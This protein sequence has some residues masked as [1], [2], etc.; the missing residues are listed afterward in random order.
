MSIFRVHDRS[1]GF[2]YVEMENRKGVVNMSSRRAKKLITPKTEY[3][4]ESYSAVY[5]W[6]T[7]G[8]PTVNVK[9]KGFMKKEPY[10][11]IY[12]IKIS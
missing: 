2:W 5:K 6:G 3:V 12:N 7:Y 4:I 11:F 10:P 8:T 1:K 9:F